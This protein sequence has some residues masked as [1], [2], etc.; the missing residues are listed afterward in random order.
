M[1]V[2][3]DA[4]TPVLAIT[5]RSD[6]TTIEQIVREAAAALRETAR[7]LELTA[8]ESVFRVHH[9]D[10]GVVEVCLPVSALPEVDPPPPVAAEMLVPGTVIEALDGI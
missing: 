5:A 10:A 3:V 7:R 2:T 1:T 6:L 9:T 8:S 4:P